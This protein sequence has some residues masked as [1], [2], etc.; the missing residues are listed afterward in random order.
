MV[1]SFTGRMSL[2]TVEELPSTLPLQFPGVLGSSSFVGHRLE[3]GTGLLF[4]CCNLLILQ[5][6]KRCKTD[7][8]A[9]DPIVHRT[10]GR[11]ERRSYTGRTALSERS[12][13]TQQDRCRSFRIFALAR[14]PRRRFQSQKNSQ[15]CV[16][17]ICHHE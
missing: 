3:I 4:V 6:R 16:R 17:S 10:D 2:P 9:K 7:L 13:N 1:N 15:T 8:L 5:Q 14:A 11:S 12:C